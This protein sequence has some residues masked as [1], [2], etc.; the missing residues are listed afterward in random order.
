MFRIFAG[1]QREAQRLDG[2]MNGPGVGNVAPVFV[3]EQVMT[4]IRLN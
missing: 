3:E 2:T 1:K 4:V